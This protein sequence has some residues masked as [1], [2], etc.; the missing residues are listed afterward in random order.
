M[1]VARA[2]WSISEFDADKSRELI[3]KGIGTLVTQGYE[4]I[5]EAVRIAFQVASAEDG[6]L[7]E[8]ECEQLHARFELYLGDLK[9]N[10]SPSQNMGTY[11]VPTVSL[12][13]PSLDDASP[14]SVSSASG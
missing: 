6:G 13:A 5:A 12:P 2:L 3:A 14:T 11:T 4:D 10:G 8:V 7:T 1:V 9:K